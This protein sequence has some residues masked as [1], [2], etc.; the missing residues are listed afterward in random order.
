M[1]IFN[2]KL[3]VIRGYTHYTT[4]FDGSILISGGSFPFN[5]MAHPDSITT[6]TPE[7]FHETMTLIPMKPH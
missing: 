4:I 6:K 1:A 2:S 7:K 3:L 5:T